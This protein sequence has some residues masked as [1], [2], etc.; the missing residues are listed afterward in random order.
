MLKMKKLWILLQMCRNDKKL[1]IIIYV[2]F[3]PAFQKKCEEIYQ[4]R[5]V[6]IYVGSGVINFSV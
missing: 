5:C 2:Y 3:I 4:F 1:A 6:E